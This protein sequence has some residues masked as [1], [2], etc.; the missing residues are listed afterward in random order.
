MNA[1]GGK[2]TMQIT[3]EV[4]NDLGQQ[5]RRFQDRLPEVLERGLLELMAETSEVHDE[6]AIVELLTSQP[7]PEQIMAIRPS[8]SLSARVSELLDRSKRRELDRQEEGELERY[9]VLEHLVRLA[10]AHA[11]RQ[12]DKDPSSAWGGL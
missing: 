7:S 4:P 12:L 6:S 3:I 8:P 1:F 5:L 10:K 11:Y 9:L 2:M